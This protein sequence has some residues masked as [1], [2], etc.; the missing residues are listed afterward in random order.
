M[1]SVSKAKLRAVDLFCGAGGSS[2]GAVMA[3]ATPVAALDMWELA[4]QTY[5]LNFPDAVIYGMR[6]DSLSPH[7]L[8]RDVGQFD[9][10]LASPEC[11]N[12][13][14]ARGN[15]PRCDV[16]RNTAFEVIRFAK[17]LRPRWVV[18]ENV[19]QMKSWERFREWVNK[20]ES[21]GYKT[22]I[23]MLDAQFHGTP[24]SRRRLFV[25]GDLDAKPSLP[26]PGKKTS[27]TVASVLGRGE[28]KGHPWAFT[29]VAT[30]NRAEATLQ[31]AEK[32]M[33]ALGDNAEFIMVYY[34]TDAAGGFQTLD[35][36][37]RTITT[38]DRFAYVRRNG[39]GLEM[40]MLQPS[41]LAAAMGFP[42]DHLWAES[43]RR[44]RIKMIGNAVCPLVMRDVVQALV[45]E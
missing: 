4:T 33:E 45:G 30:P 31:R 27:R 44:E 39:C 40:R 24:Q 12:H 16:S 1:T 13:S 37:L 32:A 25:V 10:L 8:Q 38:L 9:L 2:R 20:L 21:I 35:R 42:R 23:G 14:I 18:V 36:P 7:Q 29:P 41:E 19:L 26:V 34:G 5:K 15:K 28:P 6:A 11:T 43:T 17:V 3:G 22:E